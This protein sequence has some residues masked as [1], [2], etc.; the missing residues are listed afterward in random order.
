MRADGRDLPR[1][2]RLPLGRPPPLHVEGCVEGGDRTYWVGWEVLRDRRYRVSYLK[3][4]QDC[5]LGA[6]K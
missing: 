2:Q 1:R 4:S 5:A 6:D 3:G